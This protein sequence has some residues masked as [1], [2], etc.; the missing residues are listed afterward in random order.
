MPRP[1][2]RFDIL[3]EDAECEFFAR[4]SLEARGVTRHEYRIVPRPASGSGKKWVTDTYPDFVKSLRSR[5]YQKNLVLIVVT[6]ADELTVA[7]RCRELAHSLQDSELSERVASDRIV[8]WIPRWHIETW[9]LYFNGH[10]VDELTGYKHEFNRHIKYSHRKT[11][12]DRF[13][14]AYRCFLQ[15]N[16]DKAGDL[17]ESIETAFREARQIPL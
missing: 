10:V 15:D 6:D 14:E 2:V 1:K 8:L 13:I 9:H 12:V 17:L 4:K 3:A 16:N 7:A 5:R 11:T